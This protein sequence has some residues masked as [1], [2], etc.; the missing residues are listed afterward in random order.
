MTDYLALQKARD[1]IRQHELDLFKSR[2]EVGDW[3]DTSVTVHNP[4]DYLDTLTQKIR[5]FS[6]GT[7]Q[8]CQE[9]T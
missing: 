7:W 2:L 4:N 9:L 6:D 8:Y 5:I 3:E 1:L